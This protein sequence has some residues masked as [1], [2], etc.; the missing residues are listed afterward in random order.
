MVRIIELFEADL[1]LPKVL[2]PGQT[3]DIDAVK[4][5]NPDTV[6]SLE[7]LRSYQ[8]TINMLKSKMQS[9]YVRTIN[10]GK[11]AKTPEEKA[12]EIEK[13]KS[14]QEAINSESVKFIREI[15]NAMPFIERNCS[16]YLP[17]MHN[18]GFLYRGFTTQDL[19]HSVFYGYPRADRKARDS[20]P[21]LQK[22]FDK[23]LAEMG[24][25]ALRRNS[26]FVS[27]SKTFADEYGLTFIIIPCND[28]K[29]AWSK[30]NHDI[31]LDQYN[32][33]KFMDLQNAFDNTLIG[34]TKYLAEFQQIFDIDNRDL[35]EAIKSK[36][37]IWFKGHYV[38]ILATLEPQLRKMLFG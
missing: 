33:P 29:F 18:S 34:L 36:H 11:K 31:I 19:S 37:E 1:V 13:F 27:G 25:E 35:S 20:Y 12:A 4:Q 32:F 7:Q 21:T 15:K 6:K 14:A 2:N 22:S 30:K 38:A 16:K 9:D 28:A 10:T 8:D 26:L 3:S 17:I 23:A 5:P 24:V